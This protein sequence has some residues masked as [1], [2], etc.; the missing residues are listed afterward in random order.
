MDISIIDDFRTQYTV[1]KM[2]KE[3]P[4]QPRS[5]TWVS[6]L[7]TWLAINDQ[8]KAKMERHTCQCFIVNSIIS[9]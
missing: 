7:A 2:L 5:E 1:D 3:S 6:S 9:Y 4:I 8:S